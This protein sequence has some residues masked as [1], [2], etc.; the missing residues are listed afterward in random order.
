MHWVNHQNKKKVIYYGGRRGLL[1]LVNYLS[2]AELVKVGSLAGKIGDPDDD[3][4]NSFQLSPRLKY[5]HMQ[6]SGPPY[7]NELH[8]TD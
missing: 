7:T 1:F 3:L 6:C 4:S 2:L 5:L 8:C